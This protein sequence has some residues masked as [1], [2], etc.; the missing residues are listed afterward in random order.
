MSRG[1]AALD[2]SNH[3]GET[4][5]WLT[6]LKLVRSLGEFDLDPCGFPGHLTAK[7]SIILP[8]NGLAHDW[9]GRVWLNPPYGKQTGVWLDRLQSHGDGI[10]IV[11]ARMETNWFQR[12]RPDMIF[13]IKGRIKF[14][15]PDFT[16]S[17]NAGHGSMLL[18]FGRRNCGAILNSNVEG[19]WLK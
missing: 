6:P 17:T 2:N 5:T 14:L 1:F 13:L 10:A 11:F 7:R 9:N 16:E 12:L 15:R 3:Q 19:V 4:D 18:A 8:D